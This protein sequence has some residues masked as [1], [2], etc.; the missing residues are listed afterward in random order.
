M[1]Q[2]YNETCKDLLLPK[3]PLAVREDPE[4][5]VCINGLSLHKV[6]YTKIYL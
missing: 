4:K 5:G 2:I 1:L 6:I 3:G